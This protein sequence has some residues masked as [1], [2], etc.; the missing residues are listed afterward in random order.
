MLRRIWLTTSTGP[1][2]HLTFRE[3]PFHSVVAALSE[4][5]RCPVMQN[6]RFTAE[7]GV[8]LTEN[9]VQ[10]LK[11]GSYKAMAFCTLLD[12]ITPAPGKINDIAF[13]HSSELRVNQQTV[14]RVNLRGL[15][16]K[17]G[18]TR[19]AD[20]TRMLTLKPGYKNTVG[21]MYAMTQKV[22]PPPQ[23]HVSFLCHYGS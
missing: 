23:T 17:P 6:N 1:I 14:E 20:I 4:I 12:S 2:S 18:T 9:Q 16:G 7:V 15:K 21:L 3:S 11:D 8:E 19:P 10:Q 22:P 5:K 13:P